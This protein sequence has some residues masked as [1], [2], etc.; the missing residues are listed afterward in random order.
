MDS[1]SCVCLLFRKC[2]C[3]GGIAA[4]VREQTDVHKQKLLNQVW[5][6]TR[7]H[8][9]C[10]DIYIP[11]TYTLLKL[12]KVEMNTEE[13]TIWESAKQSPQFCQEMFT[14]SG[15]ETFPKDTDSFSLEMKAESWIMM[16][17]YRLGTTFNLNIDWIW[18][19]WKQI[20]IG[21]FPSRTSWNETLQTVLV[22]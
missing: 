2:C 21:S 3:T 9:P 18:I 10:M 5:D 8:T 13:S 15:R 22:L 11:S 12:F 14:E 4:G 19:E 7:L 16:Y 17:T 6:H 20:W 1:Q